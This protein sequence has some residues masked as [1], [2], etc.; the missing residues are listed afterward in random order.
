MAEEDFDALVTQAAD[1]G[2]VLLVAAAHQE[3]AR[4]Q[5]LGDRAHA[6]AADADDVEHSAL[7]GH[8]HDLEVL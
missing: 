6:D 5:D 3:A 7:A 2:A 8:L 4:E 1:V